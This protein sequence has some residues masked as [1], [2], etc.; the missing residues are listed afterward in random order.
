M[1]HAR[2]RQSR[3][4]G[5]PLAHPALSGS[6][7]GVCFLPKDT[8]WAPVQG[9]ILFDVPGCELGHHGENVSF[10]A[11]LNHYGLN[12]P[13]LRLLAEIVRAADSHP[14][15]PHPAGEGL[16]WVAHGFSKPSLSDHELLDREFLLYDA[17]YTECRARSASEE[18]DKSYESN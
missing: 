10:D 14:T 8:D 16:R 11:I 2:A 5:L 3:S 7:S 9:G 13:A 4:G 1:D 17:L 18:S 6:R 12:D 15:K